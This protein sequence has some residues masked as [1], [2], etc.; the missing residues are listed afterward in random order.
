MTENYD[1][2]SQSLYN[3][4]NINILYNEKSVVNTTDFIHQSHK[5]IPIIYHFLVNTFILIYNK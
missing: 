2:N 3:N 1:L 4:S 5:Q